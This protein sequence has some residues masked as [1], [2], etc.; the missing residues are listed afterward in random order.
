MEIIKVFRYIGSYIWGYTLEN[1]S[2]KVNPVLQV[3]Y[4]NGKTLLNSK[5]VNYSYGS[6]E[7]AF[8]T[9]FK[10]LNIKE[11]KLDNVLILGFGVGCIAH[12]LQKK[13]KIDAKIVG[14][15]KDEKVIEFGVKYF[16][17]LKFQNVSVIC[18]DAIDYIQ[19]NTEL[20]DMIIVDLFIDYVVPEKCEQELFLNNIKRSLSQSGM[21][22]FNKLEIK[23][24][25]T[26]T[27]DILKTS[28]NNTM[29][30]YIIHQLY[31]DEPNY[32]FVYNKRA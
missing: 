6:C 1:T 20:F 18:D 2:S 28:F 21:L 13:Y 9:I 30:G 23:K 27:L 29:P 31:K 24:Q 8:N 14:I 10:K 4:I 16:D 15:E 22:I 5:N 32:M 19:K 11:R 3:C 17:M 25:V 26:S 7:D 12:L